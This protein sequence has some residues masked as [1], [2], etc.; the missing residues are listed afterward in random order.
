MLATISAWLTLGMRNASEWKMP[1][2]VV[3][4]PVN[5]PRNGGAAAGVLAADHSDEG[6]LDHAPDEVVLVAVA[7]PRE[8]ALQRG[9]LA[10]V[11]ATG[12]FARHAQRAT[13]APQAVAAPSP[14]AF[15]TAVGRR[16][17]LLHRI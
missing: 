15:P 4:P 3:A 17:G 1:P 5:A 7:Q 16:P 10:D 13:R 9:A 2:R 11:L 6:G 8:Q 14:R 12:G